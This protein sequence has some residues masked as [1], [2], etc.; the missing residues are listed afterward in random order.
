MPVPVTSQEF[1]ELIR[2]SG[3]IDGTRLDTYLSEQP[4]LPEELK[5][6]SEVLVRDGLLTNF[7]AKQL[8]KGRYRG[9]QVGKYK[10]LEQ[11]GQGGMGAVYLCEHLLM[12]RRV[13]IK[14]L[15]QDK[16]GDPAS[17]ER[18]YREARAV[19][20]LDHPNIVRAHDIDQE[21]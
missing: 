14:V 19:A 2:K 10:I 21:G 1:I 6:L 3:L 7:Q 17:L 5:S 4:A 12:R 18:F 16:A 13:A 11:L 20:A 9:F 15:P 8:V